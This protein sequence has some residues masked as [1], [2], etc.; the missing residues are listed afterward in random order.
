MTILELDRELQKHWM[1]LSVV[2]RVRTG[3]RLYEAEKAILEWI[4]PR[5]FCV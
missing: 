2:E 5:E 4:A 1:T 3:C